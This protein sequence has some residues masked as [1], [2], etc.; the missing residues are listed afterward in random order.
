MKK[1]IMIYLLIINLVVIIRVIYIMNHKYN[2]YETSNTITGLTAPRGRILDIKGNILV[3]NIGVKSLIFNPLKLSIKDKLDVASKLSNIIRTDENIDDYH[4]RYFYYLNNQ[5]KID[6]L[7]KTNILKK[8]EQRLISSTDLLKYKLS[9]ISN[10]ELAKVNKNN[11]YLFYLM[12]NGYSYD[13]KIIKTNLT[14]EEY[15]KINNIALKGIRTEITWERY[16]PYGNTL[17]DVFGSVTSYKEGILYE[18]KNHYLKKGYNLNDRVGINNLEYLYDEYLKGTKTKYT[19]NNNYLKLKKSYLKGHDLVL[20]IDI[21]MQ[22]KIE[23]ILKQEIIKAKNSPNSKYFNSSYIVVSNPNNGS[24]LALVG[25]KINEDGS[26]NDYSYYNALNSFT[27]GSVVK[28]A[29]IS[30]GYQYILINKNKILDGCVYLKNQKGKCSWKSLGYINDIDALKW[31]SNYYQYLLAIKLT[32]NNYRPNIKINATS[33]HFNIYRKM[34]NSYGLGSLSGIDLSNESSGIKGNIISDDLLLNY[35]IGQ[36]DTYTPIELSSY[37]NTIAVGKRYKL[38][39][40]NEVLNNDGTIY[41][42]NPEVLLNEAPI[43]QNDLNRIRMGFY[44]VN[45]GGTGYGYVK[46]SSAGKTGT[47]ESFIDTDNNGIIDK[48]TTTTSYVMYAPYNNPQISII[49]V[50][51]NIKYSSNGSN[52]KYPINQRV[53]RQVTDLVLANN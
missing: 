14:D 10:E 6:S 27:V 19:I 23:E 44:E 48:K 12:N 17:R 52:Y 49:M 42:K 26:F 2:I 31:S 11:A 32:G 16:Y 21:N 9:L 1:K 4:L 24:I 8:Y 5:A 46:S 47:S 30:V 53:I 36:Y 38:K 28:G 37:I 35:A 25:Q 20:N 50:S 45:N 22:L 41:Y 51:P 15:L 13:D 33:N 34:F 29:S 18:L 7:V 39:L 43:N 40:L 3:D